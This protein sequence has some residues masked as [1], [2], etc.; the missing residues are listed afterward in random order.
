MRGV[1][2]IAKRQTL[3]W[4]LA[5][6]E[7][8]G[9]YRGSIFGLA[10]SFFNPLLMLIVYTTF[11]TQ[12][13][14]ARWGDQ[15]GGKGVFAL[16]LFVGLVIHGMVAESATRG[17]ACI[18]G[19]PNFVKKVIF[20]IEILPWATVL[21]AL[22]HAL[23]GIAVLLFG[24]VVVLHGI[25]FLAL[26]WP[27]LLLPLAFLCVGVAWLLS[28]CAVYFRD[29]G[30]LVGL[31]VMVLLFTAPVFFPVEGLPPGF[32]TIVDWNPLTYPIEQSRAL[33]LWGEGVDWARYLR[34]TA[35]SGVFAMISLAL[36][37]RAQRGF[38]D[39]L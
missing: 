37:R 32:R 5:R 39:V 28:A 16:A 27:L 4:Q 17:A 7:V 9:R 10:W 13:F 33:L 6:R 12:V 26:L 8:I 24:A 2:A 36:F 34:Y 21:A 15:G 29:I 19:N 22:F 38:A 30:Q 14:Q 31:L 18:V 23:L 35:C 3:A 20:P 11:F 25:S 1:G